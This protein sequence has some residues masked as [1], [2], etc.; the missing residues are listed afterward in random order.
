VAENSKIEWTQSTWNPLAG[1]TDADDSCAHC[2][3]KTMAERLAAMGQKKYQGTTKRV[4]GHLKW[5]GQ[6]NVD[7]DA[8]LIPLRRKKPT[9]YFVNSMSDLF[10]DNVSTEIILKTYAA[11]ALCQQ[12]T[13]QILTKRPERAAEILNDPGIVAAIAY[14]MGK[15]AH[16]C[17]PDRMYAGLKIA[18][19][20]TMGRKWPLPN[21]HLLISAG[22][23]KQLDER[24]PWLLKCPAAVRGLS[25]EPLLEGLD[26]QEYL[27]GWCDACNGSGETIEMACCGGPP[28]EQRIE[29]PECSGDERRA[30]IDWV[31]VGGESGPGARPCNI[32]WIR[33]IVAQCKAAG[34]PCFVKQLGSEPFDSSMMSPGA[35]AYIIGTEIKLSDRKGGDPTEWP[36]DLRVREM[37]TEGVKG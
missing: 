22:R 2:Y 28:V 26:V 23:Q 31:I 33:S 30:G 3:A 10:H 4:N 35:A 13:M 34:V 16:A 5:T 8:L 6:I 32:E 21:V 18:D 11:A 19:E 37:P 7:E 27:A 1:C 9:T 20:L 36:L 17:G 14:Q 12:H 25:L 24:A 15:L 29:C